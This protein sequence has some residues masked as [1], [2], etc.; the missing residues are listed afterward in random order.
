MIT[1]SN[2][3]KVCDINRRDISEELK[4]FIES[5]KPTYTDT[6]MTEHLYSLEQIE[7]D[8]IDDESLTPA[9]P[10]YSEYKM[11]LALLNEHEAGYVR[12]VEHD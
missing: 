3:M 6:I 9:E 1:P 5:F 12:I 11:L 4:K 8:L 10:V 2:I 7:D